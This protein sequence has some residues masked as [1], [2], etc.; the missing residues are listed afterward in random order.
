[1]KYIKLFENFENL[2]ELKHQIQ[3]YLDET[4]TEDWFAEST[5]KNDII[6]TRVQVIVNKKL[7]GFKSY[8]EGQWSKSKDYSGKD[9]MDIINQVN[10]KY[11]ITDMI[12]LDI[13]DEGEANYS[14]VVDGVEYWIDMG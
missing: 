4:Y 13:E 3:T 5:T 9:T 1:M 12:D 7:K 14:A 6:E 2:N 11:N 8:E 10:K